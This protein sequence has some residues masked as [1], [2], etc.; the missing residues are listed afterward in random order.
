MLRLSGAHTALNAALSVRER[1]E[2]TLRP[3]SYNHIS[4]RGVVTVIAI[5]FPSG[6]IRGSAKAPSRGSAGSSLPARS[7]HTTRR[8][9]FHADAL[10]YARVPFAE[11]AYAPSP[12]VAVQSTSLSTGTGVP[13][14]SSFIGSN[15]TA[16]IAPSSA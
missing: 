9:T 16:K 4:R 5:H 1:R 7:T 13:Y 11:I 2:S 12:S 8:S 6:D 10:R 15:G 14:T 3:I